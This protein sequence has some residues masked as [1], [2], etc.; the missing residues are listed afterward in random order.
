[1]SPTDQE[2]TIEVNGLTR[3]VTGKHLKHIF[4]LYGPSLAAVKMDNRDW[5]KASVVYKNRKDA[6]FAMEHLAKDQKTG[7]ETLID[8][9]SITVNFRQSH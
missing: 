7:R 1:M 9:R 5:S 2:W 3:R 6:L 8:G 4:S